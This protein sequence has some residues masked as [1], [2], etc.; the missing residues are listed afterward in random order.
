MTGTTTRPTTDWV[1]VIRDLGPALAESAAKHDADDSFVA[2][3]YAA[4]K[5]RGFFAHAIPAE[6]GGGGA[7][8]G[9][10]IAALREIAHFCSSTA[11]ACAMHTHLVASLSYLWRHGNAA[12][13]ALL[14]RVATE[15]LVLVSTGGSD[16]LPGSGTLTKVDGGF[17][18]SG[19]KIFGSGGPAGDLLMTTGIYDDPTDGPTVIHFSIPLQSEGVKPQNT[20]RVLGMRGTASNDIVLDSVFL[21]DAAM[22]GVHRP[23]GKWHPFMHTVALVALPVIYA[24]YVGVAEAARD[25]ALASAQ[26][27]KGSEATMY[28]VGEMDNELIATQLAHRSM[29]DLAMNAT[30]GPGSTHAAAARRT[31][32]G[33][34]AIRTVEK[35]MEVVGGAAFFRATGL[36]RLFR[37]VQAARYH[38]LQEKAQLRYSGRFLLGLDIDG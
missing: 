4:L 35:A 19:R 13:E 29:V 6:L 36:E 8:Y 11:L 1:G 9:E 26:K 17:R 28:L 7:P 25:L 2:E 15:G 21:P 31:L 37:D 18:M 16:W 20:W 5:E 34:H 27:G 23:A 22:G 24:A 10:T 33:R 38:P 32:V 30:P 3:S 14:R 12:P